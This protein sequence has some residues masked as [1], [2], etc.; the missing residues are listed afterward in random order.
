M[1]GG[2]LTRL[3]SRPSGVNPYERISDASPLVRHVNRALIINLIRG[4][5]STVRMVLLRT[6]TIIGYI[7]NQGLITG[8]SLCCQSCW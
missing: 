6:S 1:R 3:R 8:P 4:P 2:C 5:R 7:E